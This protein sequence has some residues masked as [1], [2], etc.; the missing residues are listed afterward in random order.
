[1][2]S[3]EVNKDVYIIKVIITVIVDCLSSADTEVWSER[4][5]LLLHSPVQAAWRQQLARGDGECQ[6]VAAERGCHQ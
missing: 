5:R 3:F 4:W 2:L 1:M 6:Q